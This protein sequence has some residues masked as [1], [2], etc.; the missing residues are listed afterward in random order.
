M[1][2]LKQQKTRGYSLI[3][4]MVSITLGLALVT[5]LILTYSKGKSNYQLITTLSTLHNEAYYA[6]NQI[7][8][9]ALQAGFFGET[10]HVSLIQGTTPPTGIC[11]TTI[12]WGRMIEQAVYGLNDTLIHNSGI[13]YT[14]CIAKKDYLRG[15]IIIFR[16]AS[17]HTLPYGDTQKTINRH[18]LYL[19]ST[20]EQGLVFQGQDHQKNKL[21]SPL[22]T[23]RELQAN[24]YYI[25][26]AIGKNHSSCKSTQTYPSLYRETLNNK[27]KPQREEIAQG[28]EDLQ[29]QYGIDTDYDNAVNQYVDGTP[30]TPWNQVIAIRVWLLARAACPETGFTN[31]ETYQLGEKTVNP[32]DSY[33]R[34]LLTTTL[35]LHHL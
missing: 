18:R 20:P 3:E 2:P 5:G 7:R 33:R 26:P 34:L 1:N 10:L 29:I 27:G 30:G 12:Q 24:A 16:S 22:Q 9:H 11:S 15:D 23:L 4:L 13:D 17:Q 8:Q 21:P 25:G 19:L 14:G 6:L 31:T 28:I 35:P 32:T